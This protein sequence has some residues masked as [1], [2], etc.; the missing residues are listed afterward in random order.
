MSPS[1]PSFRKR[2][3]GVE[4]AG[5]PRP[6]SGSLPPSSGLLEEALRSFLGLTG[7]AHTAQ[8]G[9]R[10]LT[11]TQLNTRTIEGS[12]WY[13]WLGEGGPCGEDGKPLLLNQAF[14]AA[15]GD[16]DDALFVAVTPA[17]T[18]DQPPASSDRT[19]Q[20]RGSSSMQDGGA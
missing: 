11:L 18:P 4:L 1:F 12:D 19:P 10:R 20:E 17:S 13:V 3:G 6:S 16:L 14:S 15:Y 9:A 2:G 8:S 5:R 7:A